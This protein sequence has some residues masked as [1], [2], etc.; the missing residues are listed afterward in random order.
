MKNPNIV[1]PNLREIEIYF[2]QKGFEREDA[3][4]FFT[5][6]EKENW[7]NSKGKP[8]LN[9]RAKANERMWQKQRNNSYLRSKAILF[10]K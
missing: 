4:S 10:F 9:W 8:L 3:K 7:Q 2:I 1:F 5:E 6:F